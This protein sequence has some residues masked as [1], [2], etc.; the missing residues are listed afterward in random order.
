MKKRSSRKA[1]LP[2]CGD[3]HPD[4]GVDPRYL[5]PSG[6]RP[7]RTGRTASLC[8]HVRKILSLVFAGD[9][10][11]ERFADLEVLSVEPARKG[12]RLVVRVRPRLASSDD[13]N[14]LPLLDS[15]RPYLRQEVARTI[16]RRRAPDFLFEVVPLEGGSP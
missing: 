14:L 15:V 8:K 11:D 16:R 2:L 7:V 4:D 3:V 1:L 13:E 6:G 12:A 9:F 5:T 10:D